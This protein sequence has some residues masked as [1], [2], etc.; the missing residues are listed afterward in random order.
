[1][2]YR[3]AFR[4]SKNLLVLIHL[5]AVY[6]DF[7]DLLACGVIKLYAHGMLLV[8]CVWYVCD[9]CG[10]FNAFL[11]AHMCAWPGLNGSLRPETQQWRCCPAAQD[12]VLPKFWHHMWDIFRVLLILCTILL[13]KATQDLLRHTA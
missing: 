12:C 8:R 6:N 9:C 7:T 1:M 11:Y 3:N 10:E 13:S 5:G 2:G 4:S